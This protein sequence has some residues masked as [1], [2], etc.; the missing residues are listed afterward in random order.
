MRFRS[1][2][3]E[4]GKTGVPMASEAGAAKIL[5]VE[6]EETIAETLQKIFAIAGYECHTF[7]S[8]EKFLD[9]EDAGWI[10]DFALLDVILPGMDGLELAFRLQSRYPKT[11]ITL[12]SGHTQTEMIL[13]EAKKRGHDFHIVAKPIHPD[14]LLELICNALA[15]KEEKRV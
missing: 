14:A 11:R 1:V 3:D 7:F 9:Q 4:L 8:A 10:P 5:V 12:F 13:K 6:D 2:L 15:G